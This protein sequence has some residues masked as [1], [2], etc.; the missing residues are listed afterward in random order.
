MIDFLYHL[1]SLVAVFLALAV[2]IVLG[3][4]P[5]KDP[6]GATLTQSVQQL[7]NDRDALNQQLKT[8]QAGLDSRDA[9]IT[10]MEHGLVADQLGGRSVVLV[11]L[12][13]A[14]VDAVKPL[15]QA[16]IDAGGKVTGRIDVQNGWVDPGSRAA[17]EQAVRTITASLGGD[18]G[19]T[20]SPSQPTP[21]ASTATGTA[22]SF[23]DAAQLLARAVVTTE[24]SS[25]EKSD[26]A[27]KTVLDGLGRAGLIEVNGD[28]P[29]RATQAVLLVPGVAQLVH[30]AAPSPTPTVSV[31]P[32]MPWLALASALDAAS[33]GTV[34]VGPA[35]SAA[36]GGVLAAVRAQPQLASTLSTV[37]TGGTPMGDVTTV[38]ALREQQLGE[39]GNYG[40]ADGASAP[41]PSA[42][43]GGS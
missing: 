13:G 20:A 14:D 24:L 9:F 28:T 29:G 5:L 30:G 31:D 11:T 8:A 40:F 18:T 37:D 33:T 21:Q 10:E 2:G 3:A 34:V 41:V 23:A 27:E 26:A 38:F 12:P 7:R 42:A 32:A 43:A 6:I 17:R 36:T 19:T 4:G 1:V 16:I 35:S 22:S 25:S 15:T 39:A